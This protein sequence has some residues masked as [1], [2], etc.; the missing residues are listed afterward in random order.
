MARSVDT[1]RKPL[2]LAAIIE[3][4]EDKPLSGLS[5]RTLA[6]GL[7]VS[8]YALVYH[9]GTKDQLVNELVRAIAETQKGAETAAATDAAVSI[10]AHLTQLAASVEW[11]L[12]PANLSLQRLEFEAAMIE[13]IHPAARPLVHLTGQAGASPAVPDG[14]NPTSQATPRPAVPDGA[15][16]TSTVFQFWIDETARTL[17]ALGLDPEQAALESRIFNTAFYGFQYDIVVNQ[18]AA[19]ARAAF[20]EMLTRYEANLRVLLDQKRATNS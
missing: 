3:Y 2:L 12:D 1:E 11:A 7:G 15:N 14:Q 4:F 17:E 8:S 10:E 13:T 5:F 20:A 18:D 6:K 19:A 9:F 16:H